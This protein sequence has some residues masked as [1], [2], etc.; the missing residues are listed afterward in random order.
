MIFASEESVQRIMNTYENLEEPKVNFSLSSFLDSYPNFTFVNE[1]DCITELIQKYESYIK[2]HKSKYRD[3]EER[4]IAKAD[5]LV[6]ILDFIENKM[7]NKNFSISYANDP[8]MDYIFGNES[9]IKRKYNE[10][11][12]R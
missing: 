1:D 4:Y 8:R 6:D 9:E 2:W 3:T 5:R 12:R 11:Y 7:Y 10:Y